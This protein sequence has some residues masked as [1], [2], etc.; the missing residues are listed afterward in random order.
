MKSG[1][2]VHI[3]DLY[4]AK[5]ESSEVSSADEV[6]DHIAKGLKHRAE[7]LVKELSSSSRAL[8]INRDKGL[9]A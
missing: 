7:T 3:L 5:Q 4:K 9:R 8:F 6:F 2:L 1:K